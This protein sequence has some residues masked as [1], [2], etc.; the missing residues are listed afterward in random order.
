MY[1]SFTKLTTKLFLL[2]I[3]VFSLNV[4]NAQ[5]GAP[6][7]PSETYGLGIQLQNPQDIGFV[8]T[9]AFNPNLHIGVQFGVAYDMGYEIKDSKPY[10]GGLNFNF[11]PFVRYYLEGSG[12]FKPFVSGGAIISSSKEKLDIASTETQTKTD[13]KVMLHVTAGAHWFPYKS[14]GVYGGFRFFEMDTDNSQIIIGTGKPVLGI[15]W[16]F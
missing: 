1:N 16:W 5:D 11:A 10:E 9:Y 2:A 14:V 6:K 3:V 13:D 8:G 7:V 15:D 12:S 4:A